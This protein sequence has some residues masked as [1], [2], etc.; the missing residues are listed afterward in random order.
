MRK[1][2]KVIAA[3]VTA[4]ISISSL[5]C[6]SAS[7]YSTTITIDNDTNV[8]GYSNRYSGSWQYIRNSASCYNKDARMA[9][10]SSQGNCYFWTFNNY[11]GSAN[12]YTSCQLSVYLNHASFTDTKASYNIETTVAQ[13]SNVSVG[14]LNQNTAPGGWYVFNSRSFRG[15]IK[16]FN[17]YAS[18]NSGQYTG[19]DGVKAYITY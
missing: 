9:S 15:Q 5:S 3:V 17:V 4:V 14:T 1:F 7:A 8:S 18:G 13:S 6:I 19:A 12:G 16:E 10:S 2:S 11:V